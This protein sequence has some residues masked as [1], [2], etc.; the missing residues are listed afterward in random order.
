MKASSIVTQLVVLLPRLTSKLTTNVEVLSLVRSGTVITASCAAPHGLKP[1][2]AACIVGAVTP[3]SVDTLSRSGTV[4]TVVTLADHDLTSAVA[5]TIELAGSNE[6]NFNGTF[7]VI[8]V[9][10]RRTVT[11]EMADSGDTSATGSPVLLG[12][13]SSLRGYDSAYAVLEVPSDLEFTFTHSVAGLADPTGT[14]VARVKPRI[15][16]GVDPG[17]IAKA[18]TE[19]ERDELWAFVVMG[20]AFASK[21]RA[22]RSDALANIGRGVEYRQQVVEPFSIFLYVPVGDDVTGILGRDEAQDLLRPL[23][24]S[25]LNS[26]FDSGLYV[27]SQGRVHFVDHGTF[28]FDTAVYVHAYGFQQVSDLTFDDTVGHDLDVAFRDIDLTLYPQ[29]EG[30]SFMES[31]IDLDDEPLP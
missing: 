6:A 17:Q 28:S 14:I 20:D 8:Q 27:G 5:P 11:F 7:D 9:V 24:R 25:L 31:E 22:T 15:A 23:C 19:K 3:I 1:G 16:A 30:T 26:S 12:A 4:G 13:E 2:E 29:L 21:D 10:N 18:Y